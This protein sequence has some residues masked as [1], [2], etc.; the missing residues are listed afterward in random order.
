MMM[1]KYRLINWLYYEI[2]PATPRSLQ[3][4]LRRLLTSFRRIR[5]RDI[6]PI[7]PQAGTP[8]AG[9]TGWPH[10]RQFALVLTHDVD[11]AKGEDR[12][13]DL[14]KIDQDA[15]F[16]SA[17]YFVP[18]SVR[19]TASVVPELKRNGFEVG[20]HGLFH[21]G[22]L[23]RSRR[24]FRTRALLINQFLAKW[25][26]V[27]FR[28]DCMHR[29]LDWIHDLNI[30]YDASTFDVDPFEPQPTGMTT[31]FPFIVESR[32]TGKR[33]IELP[34]T[35]PQDFTLFVIMREKSINIWKNKLDWIA[36]KGGMAQLITH[37]DY[38]NFD[39]ARLAVDEYPVAFYREFLAYIKQ[40]YGGQFWHA[41]PS[42]IAQYW[43]SM[44]S[45]SRVS[46]PIIK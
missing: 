25:G 7:N 1:N 41:L 24:K 5:N 37:P 3:L 38:M 17:F 32:D 31:I 45:D 4:T 8:P 36:A 42:E 12:C 35:L 33:Y 18:G 27:G 15:G 6:W 40:K 39:S 23:F 20:V 26:A 16:R 34:Y 13:L 2:K 28:G 10:H 44:D 43:N 11:S 22:K 30:L 14:M 9:W 21:D 19:K 46:P 29:E